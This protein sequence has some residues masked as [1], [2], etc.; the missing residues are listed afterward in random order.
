MSDQLDKNWRDNIALVTKTAASLV[1]VIG[2]PL[3]ELI[4]E[5][6]P[7]YRPMSLSCRSIPLPLFSRVLFT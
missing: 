7:L 6:I 4:S 2:G 3:A 1:P 5:A